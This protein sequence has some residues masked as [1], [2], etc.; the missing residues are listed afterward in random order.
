MPQTFNNTC[1]RGRLCRPDVHPFKRTNKSR[2]SN[3]TI[4]HLYVIVNPK[5]TMVFLLVNINVV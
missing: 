2:V 5:F 1:G 3:V 4:E